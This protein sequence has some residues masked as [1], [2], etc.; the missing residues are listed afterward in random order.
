MCL[1]TCQLASEGNI[2]L[3]SRLIPVSDLCFA[4]SHSVL[5]LL[6][7]I[8]SV[9]LISYGTAVSFAFSCGEMPVMLS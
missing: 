6:P 1:C 5:G 4:T 3:D 8:A 7:D 9:L 2:C